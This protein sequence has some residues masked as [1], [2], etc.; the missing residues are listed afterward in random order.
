MKKYILH[1]VALSVIGALMVIGFLSVPRQ[2]SLP[3]LVPSQPEKQ[4]GKPEKPEEIIRVTHPVAGAEI[5]SPVLIAGEARGTWYF[6][7]SF[8]VKLVDENGQELVRGVATAQGDWMTEDFVPFTATLTFDPQG[9]KAGKLILEK[10]NPSDMRELD[11]FIG[12]PVKFSSAETATVKVFFSHQDD[13][14]EM[15][16]SVMHARERVIAK[17]PAVVKAALEQLLAGPTLDEKQE[18]FFTSINAGVKLNS[19]K[20]EEGTIFADFDARLAESVGGSCRVIAIR[21][22]LE[23]T[24]RQFPSVKKVVI[25]IDG[26]TEDILQP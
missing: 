15:D 1:G 19:L 16:C 23:E 13:A 2:E 14:T 22:Q 3:Q 21:S 7:A 6:E 11:A 26:R 12:I 20:I 18:G 24:L 10:D 4:A 8:P 5:A 9:A 25:S 17:T